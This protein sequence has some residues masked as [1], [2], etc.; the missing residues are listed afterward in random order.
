LRFLYHTEVVDHVR[1]DHP[2]HAESVAGIEPREL[3]AD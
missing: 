1:S 2:D 3:P